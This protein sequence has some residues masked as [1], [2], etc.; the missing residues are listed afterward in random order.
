[1]AANGVEPRQ[2]RETRLLVL[3]VGVSISVLMLLAR[4]RFPAAD[5]KVAAPAPSPLA[6]LANQAAFDDM[7]KAMNQLLSRVSTRVWIVEMKRAA[8]GKA[9]ASPEPTELAPAVMVRQG[10]ALLPLIP[11]HTPVSILDAGAPQEPLQIVATDASRGIALIRVPASSDAKVETVDGFEGFSFVGL[12]EPTRAGLTVYP[13]FIG[14]LNTLMDGR[15]PGVLL[16]MPGG[17]PPRPGGLA[18]SIDGRFVGLVVSTGEGPALVPASV[19]DAT[20]SVMM[21]SGAA[22]P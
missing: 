3:V 4:F 14:R 11:D 13:L 1:M 6:G 8:S 9:S 15:W 7:A 5:L 12:V 21:P 17:P 20:V 2:G 10:L 16:S 18:F 22:G 19:V